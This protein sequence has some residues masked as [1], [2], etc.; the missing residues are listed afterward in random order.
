MSETSAQ[1]APGTTPAFDLVMVGGDIGVYALARAFNDRYGT[2]PTVVSRV[3][4]GPVMRSD[5]I[6][7]HLIGED[8]TSQDTID[9]LVRIGK[10]HHGRHPLVLLTNQDTI[11]RMVMERVDE[12]APYYTIPMPGVDLLDRISDKVEF[13]RACDELGI[14]HPATQVVD[15]SGAAADGWT[16]PAVESPFPVVAKP[17]T[18][19]QYETLKFPGKKKVY[20]LDT[21][22]DYDDMVRV[23]RAAGFTGQFLVQQL[24]GGDDTYMRSVTAYR[25]QFGETTLLCS[26]HVLLEEHS[27]TALGNPAAMFTT[28]LP[29]LWES[30]VKFLD[31]MDY[32][33][34]ANFDVKVDPKDGTG[35][36]LEMNSRI[37][38]NNY[39][40]T[41]AG[42]NVAEFVVT[43][44][45]E[46]RP[47]APVRVENE[48]LYTVLFKPFLM[49]YVLDPAL[50]E[51]V[52]AAARNGIHHPLWNRKDSLWRKGYTLVAM[53]NHVRKFLKYYPKPSSHG[54]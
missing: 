33:G 29:D 23:L 47:H 16:A 34:F 22:A 5:I 7:H 42:A 17:A 11:V 36:F 44:V 35:Y 38:R 46:N 1:P 32:K 2:V 37:G 10:E 13:A 48:I 50:R 52:N 54:F 43:D 20:F 26:A 8:K 51:R 27:P 31:H 12:L 53:A 6:N 3:E 49:R 18:T 25:D 15:F 19:S 41:A 28:A 30:A 45:V 21:Q 14:P 4:T 9:E 40:V 24:I 39:Y